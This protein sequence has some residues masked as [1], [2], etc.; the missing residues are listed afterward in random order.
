MVSN[1]SKR[2]VVKIFSKFYDFYWQNLKLKSLKFKYKG[3]NVFISN[4]FNFKESKNI[5]IGSHTYIG[6]NATIYGHGGVIIEKGVIIGP[7][8]TIYSANHNYSGDVSF[9]PYDEMLIFKQVHIKDAVWIGGN[10]IISPGVTIGEGAV[11]AA[12]SVVVKNVDPY[13]IV[14]GNPAIKIGIRNNIEKFN[15]LKMEEMLYVKYK[16]E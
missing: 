1:S 6:P 4:D 15:S 5:S 12:G 9:I 8:L 13:T 14:G 11:V 10:V 3:E 2:M 16:Y 7:Y